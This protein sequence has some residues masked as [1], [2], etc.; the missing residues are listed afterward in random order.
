MPDILVAMDGSE[1]ADR[2]A[3]WALNMARQEDATV[4]LLCVVDERELAKSSF[5]S[6]QLMTIT[7]QDESRARVQQ[8]AEKA[9]MLGVDVETAVVRGV[10]ETTILEYADDVSADVLVVGEH[11]DHSKHLGGVGKRVTK[12][13]DCETVVV[14]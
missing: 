6:S 13:S 11:G 2:A 8:A 12:S 3:L 9:R 5:S 10:P 4:H 1:Y 14:S 7:V